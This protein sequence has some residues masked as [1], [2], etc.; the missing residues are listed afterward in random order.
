MIEQTEGVD[1]N[2]ARERAAEICG[3]EFVAVDTDHDRPSK[4]TA[5]RT[6]TRSKLVRK[7]YGRK[8]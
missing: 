1:F 5:R 7:K 2:R 8:R 6:A 3:G 4:L